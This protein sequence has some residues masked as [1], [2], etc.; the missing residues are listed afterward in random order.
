MKKII[1]AFTVLVSAW[2]IS[3]ADA[4]SNP[5]DDG[6]AQVDRYIADSK[7][8]PV[9]YRAGPDSEPQNVFVGRYGEILVCPYAWKVDARMQGAVEVVRFQDRRP[10]GSLLVGG[11]YDDL[12]AYTPKRLLQ[13]L[14]IPRNAPGG[15]ISLEEMRKA[16]ERDLAIGKTTHEILAE[17][18]WP[19]S[20]AF[21]AVITKPY[22]V[23]QHYSQSGEHYFILT[24]GYDPKDNLLTDDVSAI[25]ASLR[26]YQER[27]TRPLETPK[28]VDL[29][30]LFTR[31][32]SLYLELL[33]SIP[34][35]LLALVPVRRLRWSSLGALAYAHAFGFYGWAVAALYVVSG[36]PRILAEPAVLLFLAVPWISEAISKRLGGRKPKRVFWWSFVFGLPAALFSF[37]TADVSGSARAYGEGSMIVYSAQFMFMIGALFGL[38]LGLTHGFE[39]DADVVSGGGGE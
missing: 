22:S 7:G 35:I 19:S 20:D 12:S 3:W 15:F 5:D 33:L 23:L 11:D 27:S 37:V 32:S 38:C 36:K 14:V 21:R 31:R 2:G 24:A 6:A 30:A 25:L 16:K 18:G 29:L 8:V 13:L 1:C 4:K 28:T 9:Q 39:A 34:C 26:R 17:T 10:R